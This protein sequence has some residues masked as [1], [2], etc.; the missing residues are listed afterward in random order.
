VE[1]LLRR[2][3]ATMEFLLQD[4]VRS[5]RS[6]KTPHSVIH[7]QNKLVLRH[8]APANPRHV[9]VFISMPLIN[10]WTIFDLLPGRSVIEALVQAGVPVYLIDWGRPGDED[11]DRDLS[12]YVDELLGRALQRSIRH[13]RQHYGAERLDAIGYC[14]GGTFL[15]MHLARNQPPAIRRLALLATPIDFHASGRLAVWARAETFPLDTLIDSVGNYPADLMR[16]SFSWLKPS[17]QTGKWFGL[18]ERSEDAG[19][20]ELW[21]HLEKW[22]GDNVDFPGEAYRAYVRGCYFDNALMQGGW[23]LDGRPVDLSQCSIPALVL[24]ATTDHICP[25]AAANGLAQAWGG[26]VTAETLKGGHVGVCVGKRL[27][28]RLVQWVESGEEKA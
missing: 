7:R 26:P 4:P 24:A 27:P 10:T 23:V 28:A 12:Y 1:T 25:E 9:P 8:F 13:A 14:V 22:S 3:K 21:A 11:E 17:G 6:G 15:S 18:W 16:T 5:A 2:N 19:F 20:R